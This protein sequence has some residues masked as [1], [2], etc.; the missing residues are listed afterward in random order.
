MNKL[1]SSA[2]SVVTSAKQVSVDQAAINRFSQ[3]FQPQQADHWLK[4]CPFTYHALP[5]RHQELF[6]WFLEDAMAFCFWGHPKKWTIQYQSKSIDGWWALLA[7]FQQA[8]ENKTPILDPKF[9]SQLDTAQGKQI[10]A[11]EPD[12]PLLEGRVGALKQIGKQIID[13]YD[14]NFSNF[15]TI[16]PKN[17]ID[18]V[19]FLGQEFS[20]FQ[21]VSTYQGQTVYFYKKAQLFAHDLSVGFP[22]LADFKLTNLD[23]LT[24]EADYKV[25]ALLREFGIL[26]YSPDL[27]AKVDSRTILPPDSAEEIEI[28]ACMIWAFHLITLELA[29]RSIQLNALELDVSLWVMSQTHQFKHPYHLTLTTDY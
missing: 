29:K 23:D 24:G 14:G 12:I 25:P 17:A 8:L 18:F 20:I 2:Q 1:L 5:D 7:I 13:K 6:R 10:F 4:A 3:D 11:G 28:R 21:D 16:A 19:V 9:L 15:L 26:N 22:D 27:A